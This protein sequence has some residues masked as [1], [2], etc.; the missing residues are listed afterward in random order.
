MTR[1]RI[2]EEL[3]FTSRTDALREI[4]SADPD[5]VA[6]ALLGAALICDEA[7]W[8]EAVAIALTQAEDPEVRR[9]ATL[10][11]GHLGIRFREL[12]MPAVGPALD[13]LAH[14]PSEDVVE[15]VELVRDDLSVVKLLPGPSDSRQSRRVTGSGDEGT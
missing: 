10:A 7:D 4:A 14:D 6:P 12:T 11:L 1:P 5:R 3:T 9:V 13:R 8:V 2:A 15:T